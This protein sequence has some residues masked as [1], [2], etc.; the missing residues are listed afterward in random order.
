M[1][2]L[3]NREIRTVKEFCLGE[4]DS[5]IQSVT[6]P[7]VEDFDFD[8]ALRQNPA[9]GSKNSTERIINRNL[10]NARR[11]YDIVKNW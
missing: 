7:I 4:I 11:V 2:P 8:E 1:K 5:T 6:M 10:K 3:S 9:I